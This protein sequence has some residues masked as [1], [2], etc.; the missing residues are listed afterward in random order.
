MVIEKPQGCDVIHRQIT[1]EYT[2]KYT[3]ITEQ[4]PGQADKHIIM[5]MVNRWAASL[6]KR[7][8]AVNT[9]SDQTD[10][11]SRRSDRP[12]YHEPPPP[13]FTVEI[14][15]CS[16]ALFHFQNIVRFSETRVNK[17]FKS[18]CR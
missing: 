18:K 9:A 8:A 2:H 13:P 10:I 17:S 16:F 3:I 4:G 15:V 12:D 7:S 14:C 1:D 5:G 6:I 11:S